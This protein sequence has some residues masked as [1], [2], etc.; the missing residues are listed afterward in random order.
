MVSVADVR[1]EKPARMVKLVNTLAGGF[2]V[3][4]SGCGTAPAEST[5]RCIKQIRDRWGA[6]DCEI[7]RIR[8]IKADIQDGK[9]HQ[10]SQK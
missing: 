10:K 9:Y 1:A 2:T 6:G 5:W 4:A 7:A 3:L 8:C